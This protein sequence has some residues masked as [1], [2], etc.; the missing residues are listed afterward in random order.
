MVANNFSFC[1]IIFFLAQT[2][3]FGFEF[4]V[5]GNGLDIESRKET[6]NVGGKHSDDRSRINR[7]G[8]DRSPS[9]TVDLAHEVHEFKSCSLECVDP[10]VH[11]NCLELIRLAHHQ[12]EG[13]WLVVRLQLRLEEFGSLGHNL[14]HSVKE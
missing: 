7:V 11:A 9:R 1:L 3:L 10:C 5:H 6:C 4:V 13:S 8:A 12:L 14:T 2:V